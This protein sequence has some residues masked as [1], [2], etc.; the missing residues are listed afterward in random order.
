MV[1]NL[2]LFWNMSKFDS[3][4]FTSPFMSANHFESILRFDF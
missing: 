2:G 3:A 1:L 4:E